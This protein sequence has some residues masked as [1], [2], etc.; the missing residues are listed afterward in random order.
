MTGVTAGSTT[1]TIA[2]NGTI[3]ASSTVTAYD[4]N[5]VSLGSATAAADGSATISLNRALTGTDTLQL[6]WVGPTVGAVAAQPSETQALT[7]RRR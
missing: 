1:V 6:V 3:T 2:A 7:E 5:G 4:G